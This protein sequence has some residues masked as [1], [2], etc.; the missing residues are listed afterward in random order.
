MRIWTIALF[1]I[2][3][4]P[5][6]GQQPY[7]QQEVDYRIRV[8]LDDSSHML[9]GD[10]GL[11][12]TTH[13]PDTLAFIYFHLWGNAFR[14][15]STAFAKQ[16]LRTRSA[17]FY[18]AKDSNLG[19]YESIDFLARGETLSWS[20]DAQQPGY[21]TGPAARA[22]AAGCAS[23]TGHSFVL[24]VPA[25]FSRLGHTG[26]AYQFT[27]WYPKPAVYDREGWHPMPYLD[28]GEFYSEFGSFDVE[29]T[30]PANYVVGAT[31]VLETASEREFLEKKAA[32]TRQLMDVAPP[33][34][35]DNEAVARKDTFPASSP[36]WKTIRYTAGRVHDFAWFADKR[37]F[38]L[39]GERP[40]GLR[41]KSRYLGPTSPTRKP[42]FGKT[43]SPTST[44]ASALLRPAGEYPYPHASAVMS[45]LSAGAEWNIP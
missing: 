20:L 25:S 30:L 17:V 9:S 35:E 19:S 18:F 5:A 45:A 23:R 39:K 3:S 10:V 34:K 14:D 24:K 43:P 15:R 27:Q 28:M 33:Q 37:F 13:S 16:K 21:R 42:G 6:L 40:L 8:R 26:Q 31:G 11:T 7:F 22:A 41:P 12:Y 4:L 38:V 44:A 2:L 1:A 29:I 36:E 32:Y